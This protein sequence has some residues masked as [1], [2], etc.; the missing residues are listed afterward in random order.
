MWLSTKYTVFCKALETDAKLLPVMA[1]QYG[2]GRSARQGIKAASKVEL[3]FAYTTSHLPLSHSCHKTEVDLWVPTGFLLTFTVW[4]KKCLSLS[5]AV[6]G[7]EDLGLDTREKSQQCS[8][9]IG[10]V[11]LIVLTAMTAKSLSLA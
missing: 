11:G 7:N 4:A 2:R 9:R 6:Q 10:T 1:S 3:Y 5:F 8:V